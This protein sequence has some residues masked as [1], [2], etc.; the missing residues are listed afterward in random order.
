VPTDPQLEPRKAPSQ[1][2]ARVRVDAI[3]DAAAQ[4]FAEQGYASTTTNR[5]AEH[6]GVPIG[7]LYQYF[8]NKDAI[9]IE[10]VRRHIAD[11]AAVAWPAL[12]VLVDDPPPL[13]DGL[14]AIV[15]GIVALHSEAPRLHRVLFEEVPRTRELGLLVQAYFERASR[16][17]GAYLAAC[18]EVTVADP[19]LAGR[20]VAQ[21][22]DGVTH[23]VVIHPREGED[24][25]VYA[26]ET[27]TMLER[28]L[29]G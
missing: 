19:A 11:A 4:V 9:A 18:P 23:G 24:A 1:Q 14:T 20:M 15:N 3:V 8:P 13:R 29:T 7:S 16:Q 5:I 12:D 17:I 10:L 25:E 21:V 22:V 28:Y 26:R 6:A 27:V 2:R